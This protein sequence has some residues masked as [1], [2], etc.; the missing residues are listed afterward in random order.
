MPEDS[1]A[2]LISSSRMTAYAWS[3]SRLWMAEAT[4]VWRFKVVG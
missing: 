2:L 3:G 4:A 1:D